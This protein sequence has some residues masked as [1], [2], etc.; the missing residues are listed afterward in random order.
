MPAKNVSSSS[1]NLL[2][3]QARLERKWSQ[4]H[5]ADLIGAPQTFM[6][7]RW[8][9]G[10]TMPGPV[11]RERLCKLFGKSCQE[12]GLPESPPLPLSLEEHGYFFDPA[13]PL[14]LSTHRLI[15][16]DALLQQ[17]KS[18]FCCEHIP[19]LAL[20]GLPG[21][22]KTAFA[23]T[24][25]CEP[26]IQRQFSDGVLW[27][28]LGSQPS[29]LTH[30]S[31]LG[32]L[33]NLGEKERA[34][35]HTP[36]E[37]TQALRRLI[38]KSR[39][40]IVIDDAWSIDDASACLV[41]GPYC[42]YV[43]TTRLLEVAVRF[44]ETHV[45]QIHELS[46]WEGVRLLGGLVPALVEQ[47]SEALAQ[48]VQAVGGLPLAL[49]LISSYL[50][51]QM[52]HQRPRRIQAALE[53]LQQAE[54]RMALEYPQAA[55]EQ[56]PRFPA[57]TPLSLYAV[58]HMSETVLDTDTRRALAALSLLPAKPN[59]FSEE[60]AL[61]V[62]AAPVEV[63]DQLVNSGLLEVVG[64]ERYQLHQT[65]A[66][67]ARLSLQDAG[68]QVRMVACFMEALQ[69]HQSDYAWMEQETTNISASLQLAFQHDLTSMVV[70]GITTFTSSLFLR[71]LYKLA[72]QLILQGEQQA[73]SSANSLWIAQILHL[74]G[75]IAIQLGQYAL[76]EQVWQE[77]LQ[78]AKALDDY[79]LFSR[80]LF[81]LSELAYK[82]GRYRDAEH[83]LQQSLDLARQTNM[84]RDICKMLSGLGTLAYQRGE[85]ISAQAAYQEGLALALQLDDTAALIN[86]LTNIGA[87]AADQGNFAQAQEVWQEGLVS[88]RH[89]S[90]RRSICFLLGNIGSL[91]TEQGE[92]EQAWSYLQE[93]LE[94][95]RQIGHQEYIC[96]MLCNLGE[97]A[98]KWRDP[99]EAK[100][101]LQEGLVLAQQLGHRR[102]VCSLLQGMA[103]FHLQQKELRAAQANFSAALEAVPEG[104]QKEVAKIHFGLARVY[105]AYSKNKQAYE[106]AN[107]SLKYFTEM[108]YYRTATVRQWLDHFK[109]QLKEV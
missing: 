91:L 58:I 21:V 49:T 12:L 95:A 50:L 76:A 18:Q 69:R 5:V 54:S 100:T 77:S 46:Q 10:S 35:L 44:A 48:L 16:R 102:L 96:T 79:P 3:K 26:E 101:Y 107:S 24:L 86:L 40:L 80:L 66:D 28:G 27:I 1:P 55:L 74:R 22:G 85:Y 92:Y 42:A 103:E 33:L 52:Y 38:G 29:M 6:I 37:W 53:Q 64:K 88:A 59:T 7:S 51:I 87:V 56:D 82:Q 32:M 104:E 84:Q 34:L 11:Y 17:V 9:N 20:H 68:A 83:Y 41:G 30:L 97:L 70:Q 108:G 75:S 36:L 89:I 14:R 47:N 67:Y 93:G 23:V 60:V 81:A 94:M 98:L 109:N 25:A 4:K 106:Y 65:I 90:N 43:L 72:E 61:A 19:F 39:M 71:G 2:L 8:E 31:R 15:G 99:A 13:L 62:T 57:G 45:L 78:L 63:L 73:R 105:A